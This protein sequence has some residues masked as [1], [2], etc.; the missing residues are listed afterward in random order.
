MGWLL[1]II[2]A[3]LDG[4]VVFY[5]TERW[6]VVGLAE[7]ALLL[8]V[9]F[10]ERVAVLRAKRVRKRKLSEG[11]RAKLSATMS[12]F[13][14]RSQA[15][16]LDLNRYKIHVLNSREYNAYCFGSRHIAVTRPLLDACTPEMICGVLAHEMGHARHGDVAFSR[17]LYLNV[18]AGLL[19]ISG[20][21]IISSFFLMGCTLAIFVFV[22]L[23][24][25]IMAM[26]ATRTLQYAVRYAEQSLRW[27]LCTLYKAINSIFSRHCEYG[28]DRFS[29]VVGYGAELES[30]LRSVPRHR[31]SIFHLPSVQDMLYG[32]HPPT[33]RRIKKISRF[34]KLKNR[35]KE[36]TAKRGRIPA[37]SKSPP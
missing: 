28:A 26:L 37:T 36:K 13:R 19:T 35:K 8:Y 27:V 16:G 25:G 7:L 6:W 21:S 18:S 1:T 3:L 24:S 4:A 11:E 15:L 2:V 34:V 10:G 14:G 23:L 31:F 20:L 5:L 30:F 33:R 22:G 32:T 29:C 12:L 17:V 9:W